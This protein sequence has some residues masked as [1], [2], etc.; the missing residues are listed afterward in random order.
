MSDSSL[1]QL[2][3]NASQRFE[4]RYGDPPRWIV[5]APGRVNLIGEHIDYNNGFVLPMAIDRYC[6]IAAGRANDEIRMTN[7]EI[8]DPNDE[9]KRHSSFVIRH[10]S[11]TARIFSI[12]ANDEVLISLTEPRRHPTPGHWS[13][14]VA[15]VIGGCLARGM[16][17][18][19]FTAI[20][21]S[22]VPTGGGLSSSAS[23][24][25]ATATLVEAMT[26]QMLDPVD[27]ALL[28]QRAEHEFAGV[29]CGIMDQFASVL[30]QAD[31]LMLLDCRSREIEQIPFADANVTV[32]IVNSN[33]KHELAGGEYAERRRQ[34][35]SA[36]RKLGVRSLRDSTFAQLEM[37]REWLGLHEFRCARHAISEM[38]R[39]AA[40]AA[41]VKAGDWPY[42]G[43]LMY[44]SH[45][46]L[47]DDF[48]VSCRELDLLVDLARELGA[49][50][51]VFGSRMTGGGFGGCTVSLVETARASAVGEHIAHAYHATTGIEPTVLTSRPARGAHIVQV[52]KATRTD[53]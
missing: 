39:T 41:A 48:E 27:K 49:A 18:T 24:E 21:E 34:C 46:S 30:S 2:V 51:G 40:A 1:K 15:G 26:G 19:P 53:Q 4:K 5:A 12:A 43:R 29:P 3:V 38:E 35:E 22:N 8:Q 6:V 20:I 50:G 14:Y 28:C 17:P 32:L 37:H 44:A 23:L 45:D 33:V 42:F 9:S 11:L 16:A 10:S 13:N 36:A 25:V 7:D 47:R 31:H 52:D